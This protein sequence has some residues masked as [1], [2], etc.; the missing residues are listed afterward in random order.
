MDGDQA[1]SARR[2]CTA[3]AGGGFTLIELLIVVTILGILATIVIPQFSN[4]SV[5]AKENMLKDELRYLRTQIIVYKAQHRDVPPGYPGGNM[6]ATPTQADFVN[7]MTKSTDEHGNVSST[8]SEVYKYGPYL[9]TM[10]KNP[11]TELSA[12]KIIGD[13]APWPTADSKTYGWFY[14]PL[15]GDIMANTA[16]T[17]SQGNLYTAY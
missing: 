16:G 4:A 6:A 3:A 5:T 8:S 17:D 1:K 7:Q 15:T 11:I 10:P 2:S 13:T 12:V 14:R 9:S